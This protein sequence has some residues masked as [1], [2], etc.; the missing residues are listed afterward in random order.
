[1]RSRCFQLTSIAVVLCAVGLAQTAAIKPNGPP[2]DLAR[3]TTAL[4]L[5]MGQYV[6]RPLRSNGEVPSGQVT[7]VDG[8][9]PPGL[10]ISTNAHLY[11]TPTEAGRFTATLATRD[12]KGE[13]RYSL[14]LEVVSETI[15]IS[16][17]DAP[18][19]D[20]DSISGSVVIDNRL[21]RPAD[22]TVIIVA[23]NEINKAFALG[24][25][26]FPIT[27]GKTVPTI[28]FGSTLPFGKYIVHADAVAEVPSNKAI[29]RT[30]VQTTIPIVLVQ[31]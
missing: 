6:A 12:S 26:H 23:V 5:P 27:P 20:G 17:K 8:K 3:I 14:T 13:A 22:L 18:Q 29:H 19:T 1:M 30:R 11:G 10:A 4:T 28:K 16:W 21:P 15:S 9:L 31:H 7:V 25:Q 2:I 24:Y